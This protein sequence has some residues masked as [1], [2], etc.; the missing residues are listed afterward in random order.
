[1]AY[2]T[3]TTTEYALSDSQIIDGMLAPRLR[4]RSTIWWLKFIRCCA[5]CCTN[6][7]LNALPV[8]KT[9]TAS[10]RLAFNSFFFLLLTICL[11]GSVRRNFVCRMRGQHVQNSPKRS[12][13]KKMKKLCDVSNCARV[14][15]ERARWRERGIQ[16]LY[17]VSR[18]FP[19]RLGNEC[20]AGVLVYL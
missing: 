3:T 5:V 20:R 9:F 12:L 10:K 14:T 16:Q 15:K 8:I 18:N 13:K 17:T 11:E 6:S 7:P 4:S 19:L 1:M 2:P